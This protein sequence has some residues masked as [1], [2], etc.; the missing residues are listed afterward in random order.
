MDIPIRAANLKRYRDIAKLLAKYGFYDIVRKIGL[1]SVLERRERVPS[2]ALLQGQELAKDLEDL[3]PTFVKLGQFLS[4]RPDILPNEYIQ[5]LGRLQSEVKSF[6]YEHVREVIVSEFG[7]EPSDLFSAFDPEPLAAASIGQVHRAALQD[8]RPVVVKVQRPGVR[9]SAMT[10][11]QALGEIAK[12][13]QNHTEMGELYGIGDIFQEFRYSLLRELDY[14]KERLN[15]MTLARNL[16]GF[17]KIVVPNPVD[18]YSTERVLT[19]DF[20]EGRKITSLFEADKV[21]VDTGQ[22]LEETFRAYLKQ[23]LVDGFFHADPH[24][25]NLVLTDDGRIGILDLGMVARISPSMRE[26]L[27][28]FLLAMSDGEAEEAAG[29]AASIGEKS[30]G[31]DAVRYT[32]RTV[33]LISNYQNA[34]LGQIEVGTLIIEFAGV[35]RECGIR[36]P[37]DLAM[38]GKTL[39]QLDQVAAALDPDFDPNWS[40]R[41]HAGEIM[42]RYV[43]GR[44]SVGHV[45]R[46]LWEVKDVAGRLPKALI[47]VLEQ[48]SLNQLR[49]KVDAVDQTRLIGGLQ[50]I[51]NRITLGLLLAAVIIGAGLVARIPTSFQILGY[52]AIA[53]ILFLLAAAGAV[54]LMLDILFYD[55]KPRKKK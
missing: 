12:F 54:A 11:L 53:M 21:N 13:L 2:R 37:R 55:E 31:F 46:G 22:L 15:L 33:D 29:I 50:K 35:A 39:L 28:R 9:E 18:D 23:I 43:V 8:G 36:V 17:D 3:G 20:V 24:P 16:E 51:A 1:D 19:M 45:A 32:R 10:D 47:E 48:M 52:P 14:Q 26:K 4:T 44:L 6:P 5:G 42:L 40:V 49:V 7:A 25:G 38:L 41:Q 34:T 30:A 27:I